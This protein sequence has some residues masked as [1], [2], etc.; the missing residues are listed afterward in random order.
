PA[1][2][3]YEITPGILPSDE[4]VSVDNGHVSRLLGDERIGAWNI[5]C[6]LRRRRNRQPVVSAPIGYGFR[7][8]FLQ[9]YSHTRERL[10]PIVQGVTVD[11]RK[12]GPYPG[13]D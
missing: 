6:C 8:R 4:D 2:H 9:V 13:G 7:A 5:G 11:Q 10:V 3:S 12:A 1:F